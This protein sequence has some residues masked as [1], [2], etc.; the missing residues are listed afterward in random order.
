VTDQID[1]ALMM[2][3]LEEFSRWTKLSG[4]SDEAQSL[5]Y[6][7][8]QMAGYGYTTRLL[9]HPAYISL[10]GPARVVADN[11]KLRAITHSM[12]LPS[13]ARGVT[14]PLIY[15]GKGADADFAAQDVR[16][17]IVLVEGMATPPIA[18]RA[19]RAG[20][21][22]QLH[23]SP[24]EHLHE[25]CISPVWGSPSARTMDDMPRTVALTIDA[26]DGAALR[27]K[28]ARGEHPAIFLH[29]EVDT[30]W[31]PTPILVADMSA[32]DAD[33]E[34]PF[35]LFSGHQD[36]WYQGVMDNG[37]ANATMIEVARLS[38]Q[39]RENWRRNLRFCFWSGH[40]HGRYSGSSWYADTHWQELEQLCAAHVNVD[41]T[42][43][44]GAKDL[45]EAP[46][47]TEFAAL[48]NA[49]LTSEAGQPFS[50]RRLSRN[51]DQSFWGIGIPSIFNLL[52]SQPDDGLGLRNPLGWWWH[53]PEDL[54]DKIDPQIL[55]RDTQIYRHLIDR[56]L[57]DAVLPIDISAQ[58]AD[59]SLTLSKIPST[60]SGMVGL[61]ELKSE[62]AG[63][64]AAYAALKDKT[65]KFSS[66]PATVLDRL[67]MRL[68]RA[69]V[70][71][72]YTAGDR[73][74]HD[75]ALP[76]AKWPVLDPLRKFAAVSEE[77]SDFHPL[78]IEARRAANR[79]RNAVATAT[80]EIQSFIANN[81]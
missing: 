34:T 22:G 54:I 79:V 35:I 42:G 25:M 43:G 51:S 11:A 68:S 3:H 31:R 6:V 55:T 13:P 12:S 18:Q 52:S 26:N 33:A 15:L 70:P 8:R 69:L 48:A 36:T 76:Q 21:I 63:L 41:S 61:R 1:A 28:L 20:A 44:I 78:Q 66:L 81:V 2:R 72:D 37:A 16:N 5:A 60:D 9:H 39:R 32:P 27:E 65:Q 24:H 29:A 75:P 40:S 7:E 74:S 47:A 59:L 58:I 56:L 64:Q 10:P 4:S 71:M 50:G 19:S 62:V 38:A 30:A 23:I 57:T 49:V 45:H 14:G 77:T 73:F 17:A 46:A 53:T 67:F 80:R